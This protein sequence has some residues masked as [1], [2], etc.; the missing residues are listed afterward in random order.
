MKGL[1]RMSTIADRVKGKVKF[2]L[3]RDD[4]LW[5]SCEDGWKFPVPVVDTRNEQGNSP[6]FPAEEK[7]IY[8]MRWIRKHM[9]V[10]QEAQEEYAHPTT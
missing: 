1:Q 2:I 5:Y 7:G 8:F 3:F 6:T 9:A 10:Q 4:T